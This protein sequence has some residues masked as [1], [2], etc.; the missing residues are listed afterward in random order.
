M[1]FRVM[2]FGVSAVLAAVAC[3]TTND[4][5]DANDSVDAGRSDGAVSA[6]EASFEGRPANGEEPVGAG[7][8]VGRVGRVGRVDGGPIC[9][10]RCEKSGC[11]DV[12]ACVELCAAEAAVIPALCT[13]YVSA[14]EACIDE[15]GSW[16][17]VNGAAKGTGPSGQCTAEAMQLLRCVLR[18]L[19]GGID[20]GRA[21]E[22]GR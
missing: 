17:C 12:E 6:P 13:P 8:S 22:G 7:E 14:A 9:R 2:T 19:D 10:A 5:R 4:V 1:K 11:A 16:R 3:V 18:N 20:A 15:K 21:S